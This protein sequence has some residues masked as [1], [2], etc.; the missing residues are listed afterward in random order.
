MTKSLS[1][2]P[3]D[4]RQAI[5]MR[6]LNGRIRGSGFWAAKDYFDKKELRYP[7]KMGEMQ[8]VAKALERSQINGGN[9]NQPDAP[10]DRRYPAE[11]SNTGF[12]RS[13]SPRGNNRSGNNRQVH[14]SSDRIQ[15]PGMRNQFGKVA[16]GRNPF[17]N[18]K[19]N[20]RPHT[21]RMRIA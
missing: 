19:K 11:N 15:M 8:D 6:R 18:S 3:E 20:L 5:A 13:Q 10:R 2:Y 4:R 9:F 21:N 16:G 7:G 14:G 1:S 12:S 17:K